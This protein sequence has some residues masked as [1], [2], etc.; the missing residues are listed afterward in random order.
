MRAI[1]VCP[2]SVTQL[3]LSHGPPVRPLARA[4]RAPW[5]EEAWRRPTPWQRPSRGRKAVNAVPRRAKPEPVA[6]LLKEYRA[7]T[8]SSSSSSDDWPDR[9]E[10]CLTGP[11]HVA[12]S[13]AQTYKYEA[14]GR[15]WY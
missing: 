6:I 14:A 11:A 1:E 9:T 12:L 13:L 2:L 10:A 5:G 3:E 7:A 15:S 4:P 8:F